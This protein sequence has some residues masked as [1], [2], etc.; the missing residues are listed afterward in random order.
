MPTRHRR[1][2]TFAIN[3]RAI[4]TLGEHQDHVLTV[5]PDDVALAFSSEPRKMV[6]FSTNR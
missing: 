2:W 1:R 5:T 3:E 4:Y 6:V